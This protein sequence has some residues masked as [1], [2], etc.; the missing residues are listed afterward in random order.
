M[1]VT[2]VSAALLSAAL[3][4]GGSAT[5]SASPAEHWVAT[6]AASPTE[7]PPSAPPPLVNATVRQVVH[8]SIAGSALRLRLTDE[9]GRQPLHLGQ[10]HVARRA[11]GGAS[12]DIVPSTDRVVR[13]HGSRSTTVPAGTAQVSDP[14]ELP[15]RPNDDLVVSLYLPAPT[16]VA[17][18]HNGAH[19]DNAIA[20][21]DVTGA[22]SAGNARHFS[23]WYFLS[24]V[25]TRTAA[26]RAHLVVAFGDSI[27]DGAHSTPSADHRW[28]DFL[29]RRV[30]GVGVVNAG[31]SGNR[32]LHD[33]NP[34]TPAQ[35]SSVYYGRSGLHR[36]GRDVLAQPGADRVVVLLGVNDLGQ[37]GTSAPPS[38]AVSARQIIDGYRQLIAR[39]HRAGKRIIGGTITPFGGD[40]NGYDNPRN[41]ATWRAVN[42]WVRTSGAFDAVVD[43]D[44]AVRDPARPDRMRPDFDS[45]DHLHPDDAGYRAMAAAVPADLL[46]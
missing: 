27:T 35:N 13:F 11:G 4:L 7:T 38:E 26:P 43:F 15:T 41:L 12:T 14:V 37:P 2:R 33:P 31:I 6:W 28:P 29:A 36:F 46:R 40:T 45:G 42:H 24:G 25:S 44:A 5:S 32:L 23:S 9:F 16:P 21:G 17:T 30:R 1:R 20:A 39:A 10:V 19:R 8:T 34:R 3:L 18:V 22:R